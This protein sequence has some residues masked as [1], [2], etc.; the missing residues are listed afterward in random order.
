[1]LSRGTSDNGVV[2]LLFEFERRA[3]IDVYSLLIGGG[4]E[5][6]R[7]G[8]QRFTELCHCTRNHPI[9][10]GTEIASIDLEIHT[11][12]A[13]RTEAHAASPA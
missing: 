4:I 3:C 11:Y 12:P 1:V 13:T 8:H 2:N 9:D 6:S 5:L 10:C 7:N